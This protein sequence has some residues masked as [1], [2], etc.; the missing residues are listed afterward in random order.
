MHLMT[1]LYE[2][3]SIRPTLLSVFSPLEIH[4]HYRKEF[5]FCFSCRCS[6]YLRLHLCVHMR[7]NHTRTSTNFFVQ[8]NHGYYL[9]LYN[10]RRINIASM[11][12]DLIRPR[13]DIKALRE[14]ASCRRSL[15]LLFR[16]RGCS[17]DDS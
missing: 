8:E 9:Y 7:Y 10:S 2:L 5:I 12:Y 13:S 16:C 1:K 14:I 3:V 17:Q 4:S 15:S 6:K 11:I